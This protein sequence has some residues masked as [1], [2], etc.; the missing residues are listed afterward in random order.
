MDGELR[1]VCF[2]AATMDRRQERARF[3]YLDCSKM[4]SGVMEAL[5]RLHGDAVEIQ[6]RG[7]PDTATS[8]AYLLEDVASI[9]EQTAS[10]VAPGIPLE[11]GDCNAR[12]R[13]GLFVTSKTFAFVATF[14][15]T[16]SPS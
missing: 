3:Q 1:Q 5:V 14:S 8:C 16:S 10:E 4:C 6:V 7:P 12:R 2:V 11:V 9:V 13:C 15:L